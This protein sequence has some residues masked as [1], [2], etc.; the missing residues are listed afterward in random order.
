M[1]TI[2]LASTHKGTCR[3]CPEKAG[4]YTVF[5]GKNTR[6]HLC[7]DHKKDFDTGSPTHTGG[8]LKNESIENK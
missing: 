5:D 8:D 6:Y 7:A 4:V 2:S 3:F 1:N